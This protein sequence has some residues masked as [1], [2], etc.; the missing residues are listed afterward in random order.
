MLFLR[1]VSLAADTK[2]PNAVTMVV[3][4]EDHTLGN[5]LRMQLLEDREVL[6][7]GYRVQHPLEPAIQVKVQ[8]KSDNPG[9]VQAVD[10]ALSTLSSRREILSRHRA[11]RF[12]GDATTSG[13]AP[14]SDF[15][16]RGVVS[17]VFA[18]DDRGVVVALL[19]PTL[20]APPPEVRT[21]RALSGRA[22]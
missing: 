3:E 1:R 7:S 6:F 4:R 19:P 11:A 13:I 17:G 12:L 16:L 22:M 18:T 8:T 15:A 2:V 21:S 9:P 14:R 10:H 20:I 5:I